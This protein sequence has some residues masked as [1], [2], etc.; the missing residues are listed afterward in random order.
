MD[1]L[2]RKRLEVAGWQVG[3]ATDFLGLSAEEE[4]RGLQDSTE[5]SSD[6]CR[7]LT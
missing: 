4:A 3:S 2:K 1:T 5:P 6:R 7:H